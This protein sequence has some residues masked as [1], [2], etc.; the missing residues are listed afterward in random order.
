MRKIQQCVP[1]N[2]VF[3][4][5]EE[6]IG[7]AYDCGLVGPAAL[8]QIAAPSG[9]QAVRTI[10]QGNAFTEVFAPEPWWPYQ[11]APRVRARELP[12]EWAGA[13][14]PCAWLRPHYA[15]LAMGHVYSAYILLVIN[16]RIVRMT[17]TANA[18]ITDLYILNEAWAQLRG[19]VVSASAA[20]VY[21]PFERFGDLT[22]DA[23][24]VGQ[25]Q[26]LLER[27]DGE[28]APSPRHHEDVRLKQWL[29]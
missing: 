6:V 21:V 2:E 18:W 17:I 24:N 28:V 23:M 15:R 5:P 19:V 13:F 3:R 7:Y 8:G 9:R 27:H 20:A 29:A 25:L 10:D 26:P 11:C 16:F 14:P 4:P 1:A 22:H 12:E